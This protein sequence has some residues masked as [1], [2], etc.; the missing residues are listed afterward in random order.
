M[1]NQ[2][3]RTLVWT[4]ALAVSS[5][6]LVQAYWMVHTWGTENQ[7]LNQRI[8]VALRRVS[9]AMATYNGTVR[10]PEHP[11][12]QLSS[13]YYVVRVDDVIDTSVLEHYLRTELAAGDV[14]TSFEYVIY[15]C[16][17][18][19]MLYGN[20]IDP[21]QQTTSTASPRPL[22]T[23]DDYTYYFGVLFPDKSAT[24]LETIQPWLLLSGGLLI[25]VGFFCYALT[26]ILRQKRL[27]E[28]QK[29]FINN[30]THEFKTPIA[31]I[32]V[33]AD[34]LMNPRGDVSAERSARYAS[35]VKEQVLRLDQQVE[36]VLQIALVEQR[37]P[38]LQKQPIDIHR[39]IREV[40][41]SFR[42][43]YPDTLELTV[44]LQAP[45]AEV[46][47]DKFHL[48]NVVY[49]LLD[50][51][52]KYSLPPVARV[53]ISTQQCEAA[54]H[55]RIAD[56]GIGIPV[57]LTKRV[58]DKFFRVPTGDVHDVKG[59][60]LG[61]YYVKQVCRMHRWRVLVRSTPQRGSVF[62]ITMNR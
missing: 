13:D 36:R 17:D 9:E 45:S 54:I 60:G 25:V 26:V 11:V 23:Y 39:I 34:V 35:V 53:R 50:N 43:R 47:T 56:Q 8:F 27:S 31:T 22:P 42:A 41:V 6:V 16:A 15:D 20:R 51:A 7:K 2:T 24:L 38:R 49:N 52:V 10:S 18:D 46:M 57:E 48:T 4:G 37:R 14:L 21:L 1:T 28:L 5:L 40:A 12:R 62:T 33:S 29:N 32:N 3:L 19:R 30:M 44:D 58:F 55:L 61:L 59:F